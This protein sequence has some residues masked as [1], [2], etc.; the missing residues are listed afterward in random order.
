MFPDDL[1][2]PTLSLRDTLLSSDTDAKN[3]ALTDPMLLNGEFN[4][5]SLF[6]PPPPTEFT[7]KIETADTSQYPKAFEIPGLFDPL[8]TELS[9]NFFGDDDLVLDLDQ[10][11]SG[12]EGLMTAIL[13]QQLDGSELAISSLTDDLFVSANKERALSVF[14]VLPFLYVTHCIPLTDME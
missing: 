12:T 3:V 14:P 5:V 4:G 13:G 1:F 8:K 2:S 9:A 6:S 11:L 10:S 7:T